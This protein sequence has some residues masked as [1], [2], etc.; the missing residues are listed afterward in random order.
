MG[1]R[2]DASPRT[3]AVFSYYYLVTMLPSFGSVTLLCG[4]LLCIKL[5]KGTVQLTDHQIDTPSTILHL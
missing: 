3:A 5:S 4:T 1:G 2:K